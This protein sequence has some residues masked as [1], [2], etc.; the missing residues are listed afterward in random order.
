MVHYFKR[1]GTHRRSVIFNVFLDKLKPIWTFLA[2]DEL[3]K[4]GS[5]SQK[6]RLHGQ[7]VPKIAFSLSPPR[8]A[9]GAQMCPFLV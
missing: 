1:T 2:S 9:Y 4:E 7:K 6:M 8:P 3:A 5:V